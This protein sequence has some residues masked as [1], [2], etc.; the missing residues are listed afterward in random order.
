[1]HNSRR[2]DLAWARGSLSSI[3][4][5]VAQFHFH[6]ETYLA[7][8]RSEVPNYDLLQDVIARATTVL[9]ARAILDLGAGMGN[10]ALGLGRRHRCLVDVERTR[11]VCHR[12]LAEVVGPRVGI[13]WPRSSALCDR[14]SSAVLMTRPCAVGSRWRAGPGRCRASTRPC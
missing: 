5:D 12:L 14:A 4:V 8:V 3:V 11:R 1:M 9:H 6:P 2:V 13:A 10:T 7:L